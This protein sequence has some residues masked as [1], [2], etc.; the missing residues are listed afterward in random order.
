MSSVFVDVKTTE[1]RN[2]SGVK[3]YTRCVSPSGRGGCGENTHLRDGLCD[4]KGSG[5]LKDFL[6]SLHTFS[7]VF[8][9]FL[10]FSWT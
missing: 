7:G 2:P 10:F 3:G 5:V 6:L 4:R 1:E 8:L 9:V